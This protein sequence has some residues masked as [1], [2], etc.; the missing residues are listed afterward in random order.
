MEELV[1]AHSVPLD[2]QVGQIHSFFWNR[3]TKIVLSGSAVHSPSTCTLLWLPRGPT[4]VRAGSAAG[5]VS[6]NLLQCTD[7]ERPPAVVQQLAGGD[8][9][10]VGNAG[11]SVGRDQGCRSAYLD[12]NHPLR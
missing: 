6:S 5:P 2:K 1:T 3:I 11:H 12:S 9:G 7:G 4:E 8:G 10:S